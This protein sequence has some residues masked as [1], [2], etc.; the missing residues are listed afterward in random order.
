MKYLIFLI[1]LSLLFGCTNSKSVYWCGDH[2]CIN[3]K[4]KKAYFKKTMTVEIKNMDNKNKKNYS[5]YEKIL[6]QVKTDTKKGI[7]KKKELAKDLALEKKMRIKRE[8]ELAKQLKLEKKKEIKSEKK[9][10][11]KLKL[12]EKKKIKKE[13]KLTKQIKLEKDE[14]ISSAIFTELKEKII[15]KNLLRPYPDINDIQN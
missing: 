1:F 15:K 12:E 8:K 3:K 14:K 6:Q 4:E 11:K 13:K 10:A 5:S 9:L 2:A 7:K